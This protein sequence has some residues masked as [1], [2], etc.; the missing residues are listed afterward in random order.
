ME[1]LKRFFVAISLTIMLAGTA[2]ADCPLP[3]PGEVNSPPCSATQEINDDAT[4]QTATTAT[5]STELESF[6][7]DTVIAGLEHLLT[8]Y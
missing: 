5:I 6:A 8:V 3:L 7:L 1:H 4:N 2:L